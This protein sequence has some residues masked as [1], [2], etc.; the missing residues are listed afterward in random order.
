MDA[1]SL[2]MISAG[3]KSATEMYKVTIMRISTVKV[4]C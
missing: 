4:S 1:H 3:I 2:N